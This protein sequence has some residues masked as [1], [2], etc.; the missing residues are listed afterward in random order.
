VI[1]RMPESAVPAP[2]AEAQ[3]ASE[4]T[5]TEAQPGAID[6]QTPQSA[7]TPLSKPQPGDPI[8]RIVSPSKVNFKDPALPEP[9]PGEF[10]AG[11]GFYY[12]VGNGVSAPQPLYTPD[13]QYSEV[14]R[15][16]RFQGAV[17]L[18][19][20]I[21]AEGRVSGLQVLRS[22]GMGLDAKALETVRTWKFRPSLK[23]GVPVATQMNIEVSFNLY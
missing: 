17:M 23:D 20:D 18:I 12:H 7:K 2:G 14:A 10:S 15:Q 19:A 1:V 11:P 8:A 22:I 3:P 6:P 21:D 9:L 5:H 4:G 16:F 13:P